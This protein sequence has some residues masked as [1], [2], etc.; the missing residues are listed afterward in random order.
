MAYA[1]Y[2]LQIGDYKVPHS[3]IRADTYSAYDNMQDLDPW[4]DENG[5][6]HRNPL[7]L[8]VIK[9]EFETK[10]MLTNTELSSFLANIKRNYVSGK[11]RTCYVT[12]YIPQNDDYVTQLAYMADFTPKM[13]FADSEIIKYN[14]IRFAC[15][16][17]VA[18]DG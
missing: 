14:P 9:V 8:K 4:T 18:E 5:E 17:G 12:A 10:A 11:A 6:L 13:Y 7:D 3:L 2:L 15:I 16:G 1:G